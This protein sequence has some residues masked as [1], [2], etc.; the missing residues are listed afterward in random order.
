MREVDS[1][2]KTR[3]FG[4]ADSELTGEGLQNEAKQDFLLF[5]TGAR[6]DGD[7]WR[8]GLEFGWEH[9]P[10]NVIAEALLL[11]QE[12]TASGGSGDVAID[13]G[14]VGFSWVLTGEDKTFSKGIDPRNPLRGSDEPGL[15]A[16]QFATRVSRL[17]LDPRLM[18]IGAVGTTGFTDTV[19]T[20]DAGLNWYPTRR[21]RVRTHLIWTDY[22]EA[23][24]FGGTTFG[25]EL[26]V[27]V[28]AQLNF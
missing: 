17:S 3:T 26:A 24:A 15:G 9:G 11:E 20:I 19:T 8:A 2:M 22:D 18:A 25:E 12:M 16:L 13:G 21:M 1:R 6:M 14:Y 28:Q 23:I 10:F 27:L 4:R 5:S 7:R